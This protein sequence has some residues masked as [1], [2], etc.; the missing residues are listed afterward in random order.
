[1]RDQLDVQDQNGPKVYFE[2][3]FITSLLKRDGEIGIH[4]PTSMTTKVVKKYLNYDMVKSLS[5]FI[6]I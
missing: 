1:M 2:N 6:K 3:P 4:G 5:L